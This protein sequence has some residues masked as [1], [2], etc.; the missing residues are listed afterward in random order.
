M[1]VKNLLSVVSSVV[2]QSGVE[3]CQGKFYVLHGG[4]K[5]LVAST[6]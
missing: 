6:Q 4:E 2:R 5:A 1:L 3:G